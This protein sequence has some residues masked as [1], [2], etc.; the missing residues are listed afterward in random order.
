MAENGKTKII[1]TIIIGLF[2]VMCFGFALTVTQKYKSARDKVTVLERKIEVG[3]EEVLKIPKLEEKLFAAEDSAKG[4]LGEMESLQEEFDEQTEEFEEMEEEL[5]SVKEELAA[6]SEG[7]EGESTGGDFSEELI[8]ANEQIESLNE[9][10]SGLAE[11]NAKLEK[12]KS[13][14]EAELETSHANTE[15]DSG[16]ESSDDKPA[17]IIKKIIIKTSGG[18]FNGAYSVDPGAG[19]H[20]PVIDVHRGLGNTFVKNTDETTDVK[21]SDDACTK[22]CSGKS[23][24][25]LTNT[26]NSSL[27]ELTSLANA[28]ESRLTR[29]GENSITSVKFKKASENQAKVSAVL[30]KV[31][32][33]YTSL[34]NL[35]ANCEKLTSWERENAKNS[36]EK[37]I[38]LYITQLSAIN[39]A[40]NFN[41]DSNVNL[42][43]SKI[44]SEQKYFNKI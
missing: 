12:E 17:P 1:L 40:G 44:Q 18:T 34:S 11:K 43:L 26:I 16:D 35:I 10:N 24:K 29:I 20:V 22:K 13:D 30:N 32:E 7:E 39:A 25:C 36:L 5:E 31:L 14:L 38:S 9:E 21:K 19:G 6:A 3:K 33:S 28:S 4:A 37:R 42:L 41:T 23:I 2:G 8:T 27:T 15:S